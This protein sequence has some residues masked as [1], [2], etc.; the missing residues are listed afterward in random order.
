[1]PGFLA[2]FDAFKRR[3]GTRVSAVLVGAGSSAEGSMRQWAEQVYRVVNLARDAQA[4]QDAG[5]VACGAM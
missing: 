1:M 3:T 5:V 4:A 2:E